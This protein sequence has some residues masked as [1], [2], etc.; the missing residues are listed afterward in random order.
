LISS[1]PQAGIMLQ[2]SVS[3]KIIKRESRRV[4]RGISRRGGT[5]Q[6]ETKR[7]VYVQGSFQRIDGDI[8]SDVLPVMRQ[9][10]VICQTVQHRA[11]GAGFDGLAACLKYMI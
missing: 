7:L 2:D 11:G 9:E 5:V 1:L 4:G 10:S 6:E 8:L 3:A